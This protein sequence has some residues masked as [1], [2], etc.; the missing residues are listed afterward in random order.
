MLKRMLGLAVILSLVSVPSWAVDW[1]KLKIRSDVPARVSMDGRDLGVT[2]INVHKVESGTHYIHARALRS[3]RSETIEIK[4]PP[5][6]FM[7][8]DVDL[9][10]GRGRF[11]RM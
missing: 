8:K 11:E 5:V 4:V 3:G 10:L 2:P 7:A 1:G 9:H 6:P